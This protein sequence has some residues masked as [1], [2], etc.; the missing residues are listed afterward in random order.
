MAGTMLVWTALAVAQEPGSKQPSVVMA[1]VAAVQIHAGATTK[2]EMAFRVGAGF[3]VN[4]NKPHSEFLIPTELKFTVAEPIAVTNV[5]Y[6][7]GQDE[8]FPFSPNEKLSVYSGDFSITTELKA[9]SKAAGT[10]PVK[11]ELTYQACDKAACYPPKTMP[12]QFQVVVA[13]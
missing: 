1:P 6:P 3:H 5:G 7:A 10:Y 11:G 9:S 8:T 4:S 13:K 12:V 2:V